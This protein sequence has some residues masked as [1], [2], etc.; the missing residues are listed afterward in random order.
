VLG[1]PSRHGLG[2][3]MSQP[4]RPFG[5]NPGSFGHWGYGGSLGFA[6]PVAQVA[7]GYLMNR[8]GERWQT[9][10]TQTLSEALYACL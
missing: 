6:D 7:F 9:T 1:R 5:P 8:P 2:F 4:T 10:R 3:Q